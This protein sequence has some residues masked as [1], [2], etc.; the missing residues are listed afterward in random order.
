MDPQHR[1]LLEVGY[2]ATHGASIR[3]SELLARDVSVF[4]G[5]MNTDFSTRCVSAGSTVFT[6]TRAGQVSIREWN[7]VQHDVEAVSICQAKRDTML[8]EWYR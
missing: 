1:L 2:E 5:V 7:D 3:R 8:K 4:V 6:G